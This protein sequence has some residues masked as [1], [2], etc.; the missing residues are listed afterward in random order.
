MARTSFT[1]YLRQYGAGKNGGTPAVLTANLPVSFD[2]TAVSTGTQVYLPQ[3][4]VP[5]GVRSLGGATGGTSP[6]VDI[7][8]VGDPDG[9]ANEL[10]ADAVTG[11]TVTGALIGVPLTSPINEIFAGVGASAATGGTTTVVVSYIMADDGKA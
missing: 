8:I 1:G 7:G 6:T 11:E 10:A 3:G 2:P 4:A 9:L 5:I